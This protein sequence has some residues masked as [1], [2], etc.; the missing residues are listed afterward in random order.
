MFVFA[1]WIDALVHTAMSLK[2]KEFWLVNP[3]IHRHKYR[4]TNKGY[5]KACLSFG[6]EGNVHFDPIFIELSFTQ[7]NPLLS[8]W[9]G[10]L[11]VL[12]ILFLL[13]GGAP[14]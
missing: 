7:T 1:S 14:R 11:K 4:Y 2:M 9:R 5:T 6:L 8:F 12:A 13:G 10:Y 3:F